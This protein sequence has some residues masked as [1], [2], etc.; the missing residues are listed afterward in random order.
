MYIRVHVYQ[1]N[2][3]MLNLC[4]DSA[5]FERVEVEFVVSLAESWDV[6]VVEAVQTH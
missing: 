1:L 2:M 5:L 4:K 3:F 6:D